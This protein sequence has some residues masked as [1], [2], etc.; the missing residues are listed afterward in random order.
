MYQPKYT[1]VS[2]NRTSTARTIAKKSWKTSNTT[3]NLNRSFWRIRAQ[4]SSNMNF[5]TK[6][7]KLHAFIEIVTCIMQNEHAAN[8]SNIN[9]GF[10]G[11]KYPKSV[12]GHHKKNWPARTHSSISHWLCW[13]LAL[14]LFCLFPISIRRCTGKRDLIEG[15]E[16]AGGEMPGHSMRWCA[17]SISRS[18]GIV[19]DRRTIAGHQLPVH[20]WLRW[21]WLLFG[22]DSD[23]ASCTQGALSR[24]NHHFARQPRVPSNHSGVRVLWR[25]LA[26]VR[27][28]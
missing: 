13:I 9:Q 1:N 16:R 10:S 19:P 23:A 22:R 24:T 5:C 4:T 11:W 2:V 21:P 7:A 18:D 8:A 27:Q 25:M 26:Q 6:M 14:T 3:M 12:E 28:R 17:R 15:V 20:G